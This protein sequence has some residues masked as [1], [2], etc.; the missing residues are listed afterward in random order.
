[1]ISERAGRNGIEAFVSRS[2]KSPSGPD[3]RELRA[4]LVQVADSELQA[5]WQ[6]YRGY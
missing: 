2:I 1:M 4:T 6:K 5:Y 3:A